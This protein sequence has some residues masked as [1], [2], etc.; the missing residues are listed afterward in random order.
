[1]RRLESVPRQR[2]VDPLRP[3]V[4]AADEVLRARVAAAAEELDGVRAPRAAAAVDDDLVVRRELVEALRQ[5]PERD[6]QRARDVGDLPL[7]R[8]P[9]VH[10]REP[11]APV[12]L[13]LQ[14][15]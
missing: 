8:L 13:R 3:A 12:A 15:V 7:A 9:H 11:L 2:G 5:P 14:L 10:E 6:L 4:D 1:M